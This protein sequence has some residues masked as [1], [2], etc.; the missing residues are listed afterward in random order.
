LAIC[1]TSFLF[2]IKLGACVKSFSMA[3][4]SGVSASLISWPSIWSRYLGKIT[5]YRFLTFYI[6]FPVAVQIIFYDY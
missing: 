5:S 3:F 4:T 2:L 1:R 6:S